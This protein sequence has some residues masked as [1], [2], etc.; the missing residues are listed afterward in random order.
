MLWVSSWSMPPQ[1]VSQN[2]C[3]KHETHSF[4][5]SRLLF[6]PDSKQTHALSTHINQYCT[7][8]RRDCCGGSK[9]TK[10]LVDLT[11]ITHQKVLWYYYVLMFYNFI[12]M[13]FWMWHPGNTMFF[14]CYKV[15]S[16]YSTLWLPFSTIKVLASDTITVLLYCQRKRKYDTLHLLKLY[17]LT[18]KLLK[19]Q[20]FPSILIY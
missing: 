20:T 7:S 8:F 17:H 10:A 18:I 1:V 19:C 2:W 5:F 13:A 6:L 11:G 3:N 15:K 12:T 14:G 16:W 4:A 9:S